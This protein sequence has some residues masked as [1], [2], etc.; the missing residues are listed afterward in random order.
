MGVD[1]SRNA[2]YYGLRS[3]I[4]DAGFAENL[5]QDE[6]TEEFGRAVSGADLLTVTGVWG[7]SPSAPLG[8]CSTA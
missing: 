4:L 8:G 7:I 6:P 5:E 1:V 2:V 3:G